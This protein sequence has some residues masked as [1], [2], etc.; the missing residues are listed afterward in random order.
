MTESYYL[1][2][3]SAAAIVMALIIIDPNVGTW[4]DLQF[5]LFS[6]NLRRWWFITKIYPRLKY[7]QWIM[8]RE[9]AKIRQEF[10]LPEESEDGDV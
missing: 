6:V 1:T 5:K 10:N 9:L 2:I 8:Q 7:D 4:I 3:V